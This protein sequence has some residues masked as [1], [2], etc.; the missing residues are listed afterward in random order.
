MRFCKKFAPEGQFILVSKAVGYNQYILFIIC[1]PPILFDFSDL[2][3]YAKIPLPIVCLSVQGFVLTWY[4]ILQLEPHLITWPPLL[5]D[6]KGMV[7]R[8][9]AHFSR[10][11]AH[12]TVLFFR[13]PLI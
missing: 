12:M 7:I 5:C 10:P 2:T 11:A 8:H 3:K 6:E 13:S 4:G 9:K 1:C